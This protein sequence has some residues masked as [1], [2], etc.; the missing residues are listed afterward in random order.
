M[1]LPFSNREQETK[2]LDTSAAAGGLLVVFGRRRVG[3]TRLLTHWLK[4]HDGLYSQ[5]IESTK[6][7]QIE[8]VF[9]DIQDKMTT[10]IVPKSWA[11][12]FELL[13]LQKNKKWILC[14]DEFPYLVAS[15]PSL[16]SVL[17]RWLDH[18]KS[19]ESL[20]ILSGSSNRMMNDLFLNRS[21][22]LYGR[23]R[24]LM[25]VAPMSYRA[26][27]TARHLKPGAPHSFERF[28][29]VGGIPKYWEFVDPK[30]SALDLADELFFGFSP[31]LDQEPTRILYD[32]G[33]KGLNAVSL[34]ESIGRGAEKPSQMAARLGTAQ[35]NL[36]RLLRQLL[37]ASILKREIPFGE[38]L[39]STKRTYYRIQDPTL[40]FWFRVYSPHRTRWH[41]YD[42]PKKIRLLHE[43]ASTVFEDYCREQYPGA[44][45]YWEKDL[46]F[47]LVRSD[48][49]EDRVQRLIVSE[50]KWKNIPAIEKKRLLAHLS[51]TWQ[52]SKLHKRHANVSFEI[53]DAALLSSL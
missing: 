25:H 28:S 43:H 41:A 4:Q 33:I 32:E 51:E 30:A 14:L 23:A 45:R 36:S 24:K 12:L 5:A 2:E 1:K 52:R 9:R 31:Y 49:D 7:I 48:R 8:Q 19:D 46:E 50:V 6:E 18:E 26:F 29:L 42:E 37:D 13:N 47:D 16:P 3:K 27:C 34:L 39:R 22:P 44:T 53:I 40:R 38:S 35:T 11:E 21:A 10:S 15:N 20:V 17:Q